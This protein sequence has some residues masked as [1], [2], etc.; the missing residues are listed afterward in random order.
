MYSSDDPYERILEDIGNM[1]PLTQAQFEFLCQQ[2]KTRI[3]AAMYTMNNAQ[4]TLL[5]TL[6]PAALSSKTMTDCHQQTTKFA[7]HV[8]R[9]LSH[10]SR[11]LLSALTEDS[12]AS[13]QGFDISLRRAFADSVTTTETVK[14]SKRALDTL[15]KCVQ[16]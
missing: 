11:E 4:Q 10:V 5:E 3:V 12:E 2:D 15:H 7:S 14:S 1:R 13:S 8:S 16:S 9:E 6:T